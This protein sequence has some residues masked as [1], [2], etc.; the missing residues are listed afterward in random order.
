[1]QHE[2]FFVRLQVTEMSQIDNFDID[3]PFVND[4]ADFYAKGEIAGQPFHSAAINGKDSFYFPKPHA[5]FTFL[6][7]LRRG[8]T[9]REL[10]CNLRIEV[11]TSDDWWSGTDD[12]VYLRINDT[13]RFALDK[14]FYND[15]EG[16]DRDTY[17]LPLDGKNLAVS[18]I[19]YLQIEKSS[20]GPAGGWKLQGIKVWANNRLIYQ[21]NAINK[22]LEDD[23]R[24]W[25]ASNFVPGTMVTPEVPVRLSLFD[26]DS[27]LYF[28]DDHA[29]LH[30]HHDR[31]D[32]ALIFDTLRGNFRGDFAGNTTGVA[33]GGD[34]YGGR[35]TDDGDRARVRFR[36]DTLVPVPASVRPG[37]FLEILTPVSGVLLAR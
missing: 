20:D 16:G 21:N 8:E 17:S 31:R 1:M 19:R 28:G 35:I 30:P 22:W 29:D 25:R 27:F 9:F 33:A 32:V 23:S 37:R 34:L 36:L 3:Y 12:T 13:T 26:G 10:L 24:T 15:F 18:D 6:K 5:P 4:D 11:A 7:A 14:P 2:N